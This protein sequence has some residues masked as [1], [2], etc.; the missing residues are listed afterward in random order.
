MSSANCWMVW[1]AS[2][3]LAKISWHESA[4]AVAKITSSRCIKG[5]CAKLRLGHCLGRLF[6]WVYYSVGHPV[7]FVNL[8]QLKRIFEGAV[9]WSF[10]VQQSGGELNHLGSVA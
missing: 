6:N 7:G 5:G 2:G 10:P 3:S 1:A 4:R 9:S 8:E